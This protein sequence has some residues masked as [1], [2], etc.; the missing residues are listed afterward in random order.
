MSKKDKNWLTL[1]QH[2]KYCLRA[3]LLSIAGTDMLTSQ[4]DYLFNKDLVDY[5]IN[6]KDANKR[7]ILAG[8][9][10]TDLGIETVK[11]YYPQYK[12]KWEHTPKTI[13]Q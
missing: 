6:Y 4:L 5:M 7:I 11:H 10:L 9:C 8:H 1:N 2:G 3:F 13:N 12:L